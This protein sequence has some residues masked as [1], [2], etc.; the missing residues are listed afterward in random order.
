MKLPLMFEASM[1]SFIEKVEADP[2]ISFDD[3]EPFDAIEHLEFESEFYN[4]V[5]TS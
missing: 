1:S 2:P 5:P 4:P 3:M